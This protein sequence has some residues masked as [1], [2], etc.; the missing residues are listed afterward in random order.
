MKRVAMILPLI[1]C[2]TSAPAVRA[3]DDVPLP[4]SDSCNPKEIDDALGEVSTPGGTVMRVISK[5]PD[6]EDVIDQIPLEATEFRIEYAATGDGLNPDDPGHFLSEADALAL[7]DLYLETAVRFND[8]G[9]LEPHTGSSPKLS[10]Q[11]FDMEDILGVSYDNC[12]QVDAPNMRGMLGE[13]YDSDGKDFGEIT[14]D[15]SLAAGDTFCT[16]SV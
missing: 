16:T 15:S 11:H 12:I 14:T 10:I 7:R 8:L 13:L 3:Q 6:G 9:F 4:A 2:V 5:N 1:A